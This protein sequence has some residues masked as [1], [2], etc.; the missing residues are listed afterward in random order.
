MKKVNS[1]FEEW[2]TKMANV[3]LEA[4]PEEMRSRMEIGDW[5]NHFSS[6]QIAKM[7]DVI[8]A[9]TAG[10]DVMDLW[11]DTDIPR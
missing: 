4:L 10:S 7:K 6:E 1:Q 9:K 2:C 5:K 3:P 11:K 8:A